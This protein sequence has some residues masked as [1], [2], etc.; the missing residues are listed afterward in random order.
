MSIGF[1]IITTALGKVDW[2]FIEKSIVVSQS[3]EHRSLIVQNLT[4]K[5]TQNCTPRILGWLLEDNASLTRLADTISS[6]EDVL[7]DTLG[8]NLVD[9]GQPAGALLLLARLNSL[10]LYKSVIA[11][12]RDKEGNISDE[13]GMRADTYRITEKEYPALSVEALFRGVALLGTQDAEDYLKE[14]GEDEGLEY[15]LRR[16]ARSCASR[17]YRKRV[18]LHLRRV[19]RS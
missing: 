17:A 12:R 6:H 9:S 5:H 13:E 8:K 4:A 19:Q 1:P 2:D 14:L 10:S 18:P 11:Q 16:T 7:L 15:Q 3:R